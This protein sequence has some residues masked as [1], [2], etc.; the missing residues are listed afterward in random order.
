MELW[1]E[2]EFLK[3]NEEEAKR[4][5][6]EQLGEVSNSKYY[7]D[8]KFTLDDFEINEGSIHIF[9]SGEFGSV[10]IDVP[11]QTEDLIKLLE[12]AIKKFNKMKTVF[13]GLKATG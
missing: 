3:K 2:D 5:A 13:E 10:G 8:V 11:L 4:K 1:L 9:V 7:E 6:T 12:I